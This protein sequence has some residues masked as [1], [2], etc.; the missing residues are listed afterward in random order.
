MTDTLT[1]LHL[2]DLQFGRN[3]RYPD[4]E[5]SLNSL[6]AKL[7]EDLDELAEKRDLRP[8]AI[9]VTGDVAEWSLVE[10][11]KAA[12]EFLDRLATHLKIARERVVI[13]PGNH[14]INRKL[15][16]GARLMAE[17]SSRPF[18][19]PYFAKFRNFQ[20]FFNAFYA[21]TDVLFDEDHLFHVYAFPEEQVLIVGF[22]SCIRE[23]ERDLD[24]YGWIGV[25]QVRRAVQRCDELDPSR[26]WLRI[27]ALHHNFLGASN[28][29]NENL[30]DR[31]AIFPNLRKGRIRLL[32]HGH[33]HISGAHLYGQGAGPPLTIAAAGS[34][35]LDQQ[36][37]PDMPNQ[38]Q[39]VEIRKR[40]AV[41]LVMRQYSA[42]SF[43]LTGEGKWT[44]D[45]SVDESGVVALALPADEAP[46][47][48][49]KP[50]LA[51]ACRRWRAFLSEEHRYL[52]FKGFGSDFRV[53]LELEP[54]YISL[55]AVPVH[56]EME[57]PLGRCREPSGPPFGAG[58]PT[59]PL[60]PTDGSPAAP[61]RPTV[62]GF[63]EVGTPAPNAPN[64][65]LDEL[66]IG[67]ALQFCERQHYGGMVILGDPGSG[68]S[69]LLK[70]LTLCLAHDKP[71]Q[72]TG[73][74]G[75]WF[76]LL[77]PL[78]RVD[79]FQA[80]LDAV[81]R[82][83][84][85]DAMRRLELPDDFFQ[86]VLDEHP[87]LLMLDGLDE[88]ATPERR[89]EALEWI[90]WQRKQGARHRIVVTS[91]FAGYRGSTRLPEHYLE[92]HVRDFRDE[93]VRT[94]VRRWYR[95]VETRQRDDKPEW[96]DH[97]RQQSDDLIRQLDLSER[98]QGLAC[99]PLMLQIICLVH[100]T[101]G[102]MPQRRAALYEKCVEVLLQ[103]WDEAKG[104]EVYLKADEARQ[105]LR[106]LALWLHEEENRTHA[107]AE[108]V[109]QVL[110]PH[111]AR[112]L[113]GTRE[114]AEQQLDRVLTSVRDRSGL[115][116]GFDV[117]RYGFQHLSFQEF[118][119]AEEI[120]KQSLPGR[121]ID[122][123]GSSWWRE[124]TL[125]AVGMDDPR[126]QEAL[127]E[128]LIRSP[129]CQQNVDLALR[130]LREALA[131]NVAPF[132]QALCDPATSGAVRAMCAVFLREIGG[133]EAVAALR[134]VLRDP[135]AQVA[136]AARDALLRLEQLAPEAAVS[137]AAAGEIIINERDGTELIRIPAG[138]FWMGTDDGPEN[139]R[140]KH[141]VTL[142]E[143]YIARTPITNAQYRRFM[144]ATG[145]GEPALWNEKRFNQPNQP[146]VGVT[147][148]DA[149]EYCKWAGLRL[150]TEREWEKAARG[151]DGRL[152]PW[153]NDPPSE[154]LCNFN[155]NVGA[156]TDVGSYPDGASPY[157]CLD[158][159]GNV[160]E[161]CV[162][163]W[164]GSYRGE[165]DDSP[166]GREDRVLRS[167]SW[168][169]NAQYVRCV[170]RSRPG[171]Y[172]LCSLH[173]GF[174]CAQ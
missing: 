46:P 20:Q 65:R 108:Q 3:H 1:I 36:T 135:E 37:L 134:S 69:T 100:R 35:G 73:V 44:A 94:F 16:Q 104:L 74:P 118:L 75:G 113:R 129:R 49:S 109:K 76:P 86:R 27:G 120:V 24:H 80:S 42:K 167:G 115:F 51:E 22:N 89:L 163:K 31:D 84:Y 131:P 139:E 114:E 97:A 13:V 59:L 4:G 158:M 6:Y 125:L 17:G 162:T 170:C 18:E 64:G 85:A 169:D 82:G 96:Q 165:P 128:S 124:P 117:A 168:Y 26:T 79:D 107:D 159:A 11:Y 133:A 47:L 70:F 101:H 166:E 146:V 90:E 38:Y 57:G 121:L 110:R 60:G 150:P 161:W 41:A 55:R 103:N 99:N 105:V 152:W 145:H 88:V 77:L 54:L 50:S 155:K 123:F 149:M 98:L 33:R 9:V 61:G 71:A 157:G 53:P 174:R 119:A 138:E 7:A 143:Y 111:L 8:T 156:T 52:Q 122:Q 25:E 147:W 130:C 87:C 126:F 15:C 12:A 93:D 5:G 116:V 112:V 151:T 68:K 62:A 83:Y 39:I 171:P 34:A 91:R 30:R 2:S 43:G 102:T 173:W 32:L 164:R 23:S 29:D 56:V 136:S 21:G 72:H 137:A 81:L 14:D 148:Y 95:Q 78:R 28:L 153:G 144:E 66:E 160:W 154:K 45:P 63:G 40:N 132:A 141:R 106:P 10:E 48:R 67:P 127:F 19:E 142:P 172:W 58:L 140:P 92:L